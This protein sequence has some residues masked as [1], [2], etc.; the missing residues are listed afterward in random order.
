MMPHKPTD[1]RRFRLATDRNLLIGFFAVLLVVG[2]GLI[3]LV[4]GPG[5]MATGLTCM[6]G[7]AIMTGL[8][9]AVVFGF[10]RLA[11]WLDRRDE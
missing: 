8:V 11:D 4:Y 5:A 10:E 1:L 2:G 7:G 6:V 9:L 3:L